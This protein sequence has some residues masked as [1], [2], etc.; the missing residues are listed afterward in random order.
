DAARDLPDRERLAHTAALA[1]NANTLER[2]EALLVTLAHAHIHADRVARVE[3]GQI[4]AHLLPGDFLHHIH[5]RP[6]LFALRSP[7]QE[8][9]G[10]FSV[11][12]IGPIRTHASAARFIRPRRTDPQPSKVALPDAVRQG[13]PAANYS[14]C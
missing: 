11:H 4:I 6:L 3:R 10:P 2:L 5:G 9:Q 13:L 1:R 7:R 14:C 12:V 8:G